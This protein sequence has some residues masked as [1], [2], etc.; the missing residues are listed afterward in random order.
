MIEDWEYLEKPT[1]PLSDGKWV[2]VIAEVRKNSTGE[3]RLHETCEIISD[4]CDTPS[5]YI[6]SDGS[7]GCDCNRSIF[8]N[9]AGGDPEGD[10]PCG[11]G[12]YSVRVKNKKTGTVFYSEF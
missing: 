10:E 7:Y 11:E 6:W 8:F 2:S 4:G 3:I 12:A 1:H 5:D 9:R